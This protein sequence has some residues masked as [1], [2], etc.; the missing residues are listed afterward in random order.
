MNSIK[1]EMPQGTLDMVILQVV[2]LFAVTAAILAVI[3]G[4]DMWQRRERVEIELDELVDPPTL[5]LG[6]TE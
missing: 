3:R 2:V 4:V 5:R 1:S 6:L